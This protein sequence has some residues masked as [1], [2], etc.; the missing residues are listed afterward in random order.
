MCTSSLTEGSGVGGVDACAP[1]CGDGLRVI[2]A[3]SC[4][5]GGAV[6]GDGCSTECDLEPGFVCTG[7]SST[8]RQWI[9]LEVAAAAESSCSPI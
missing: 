8:S 5:D 7:G 2:W 6:D 4:D 3:E 1:I 9:V